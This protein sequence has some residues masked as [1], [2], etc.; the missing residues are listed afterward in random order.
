MRRSIRPEAR[1]A[2]LKEIVFVPPPTSRAEPNSG[3]RSN[4]Y[5]W[6]IRPGIDTARLP[7]PEYPILPEPV[8]SLQSPGIRAQIAL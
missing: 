5:R 8:M 7:A 1:C 6:R 2:K 4:G 3:L